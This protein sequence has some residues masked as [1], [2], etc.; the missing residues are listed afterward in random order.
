ML[1]NVENTGIHNLKNIL[2]AYDKM[3]TVH[4]YFCMPLMTSLDLK[5]KG[6][7]I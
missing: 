6:V 2:E 3:I 1:G 4:N 5:K 7:M